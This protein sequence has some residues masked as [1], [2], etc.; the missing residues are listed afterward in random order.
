VLY[1]VAG[2]THGARAAAPLTY[3]Q[4][5]GD[6]ATPVVGLTWGE[7]IISAGVVLVISALL[8][9]AIWRRPPPAP[10]EPGARLEVL[11]SGS[12]ANWIWIGVGISSL[13]LLATVGWTMVVLAKISSPESKPIAT[14]EVSGHQWWWEVR[15]LSDDPSRIFTTANEIHIP[16]DTPVR[17]RLIGAD[18]IHSFW[19][20]LL[21]GKTD[22]IPG[23]TN[24]TWLQARDPGIYLGQCAE[25]CGVQHAHMS[26][27]VVAQSPQEFQQWWNHQL[28]SPSLATARAPTAGY[29]NFIVYCGG[30]H[31]V[32][33]TD[34]AGVLG[35]DLSHFMTRRTIAA[36]A[37]PNDLG[38]LTA[39]I[40]DPQ[41][42]K[43]GNMMQRPG[44][45]GEQL[46][47]IGAFLETLN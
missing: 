35:P 42:L 10:A 30:C 29:E 41:T 45:S 1:A 22:M 14:I 32:R 7:L 8:A 37:Y 11:S 15:Y 17:I 26:M 2:A 25:Y 23:Q 27:R 28:E 16:T 9:V 6:R 21:S 18:V 33:G 19:V 4:G 44:L 46:V 40:S 38:H 31:A 47:E 39:W 13:I 3:L 34:A 20:P 24:E 36:G 5:F 12:G 43:P